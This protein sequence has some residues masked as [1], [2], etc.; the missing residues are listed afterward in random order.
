MGEHGLSAEARDDLGATIYEESDRLNRL[1]G[2]LLDMTRVQSGDLKVAKEL[3][4]LE[5]I[6]GSAVRRLKHVLRDHVVQPALASDLP[7][8]PF[9]ALLME[10]VLV[11]LLENAARYTPKG[12]R[13]DVR[14]GH[15]DTS[16]TVEVAD[17]GPGLP[18]LGAG[19]RM[20]RF[21][22]T[23]N[24]G[25]LGLA[26]CHAIV[27]AHG[28]RM[29]ATNRPEGGATLR[30]LLPLS[31]DPPTPSATTPSATPTDAHGTR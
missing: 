19:S 9:D 4:A 11:N 12:S 1:L 21:D 30:F 14:A 27:V 10:Q 13:I 15:D 7:L 31:M 6:V 29:W 18:S 20:E 22:R 16:V 24:G 28:G 3:H 5:E 2:N 23:K 17:A 25:G 8:V 26:I